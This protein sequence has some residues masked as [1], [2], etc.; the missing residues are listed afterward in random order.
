MKI[1]LFGKNKT[2]AEEIYHQN[3][4]MLWEGDVGNASIRTGTWKGRGQAARDEIAEGCG[5]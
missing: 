2:D 3:T 1:I 4:A 5:S